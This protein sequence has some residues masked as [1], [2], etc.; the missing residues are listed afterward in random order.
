MPEDE[1]DSPVNARTFPD[2]PA[3]VRG[4]TFADLSADV[5]AQA[6]RCPRDLIRVAAAGSRTGAAQIINSYAAAKR[7]RGYSWAV[8]GAIMV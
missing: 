6:R 2:V 4:L 7:K 1:R 5:V 3:F 8:D